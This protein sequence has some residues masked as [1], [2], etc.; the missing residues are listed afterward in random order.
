MKRSVDGP[1]KHTVPNRH[2]GS[3]S[4]S[5]Y[6]SWFLELEEQL[7]LFD[8]ITLCFLCPANSGG[9]ADIFNYGGELLAAH[10]WV[11]FYF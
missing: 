11:R 6:V 5:G 7:A 4:L 8:K 1:G 9:V 2:G 3:K 10:F